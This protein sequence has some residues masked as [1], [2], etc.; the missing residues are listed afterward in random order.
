[1]AERELLRHR[2]IAAGIDVGIGIGLAV[3][4]SIVALVARV[5]PGVLGDIAGTLVYGGG[6]V[7][8]LA[9][10]LGRDV[11]AGG[12]S[13]GKKAQDLS[14]VTSSGKAIT[15][16]HS[17][18]R[19][20]IFA[21]GYSI[22]TLSFLASL[23]PFLQALQCLLTGAAGFVSVAALVA[24]VAWVLQDPE[25]LRLGDKFAGTRV[26]WTDEQ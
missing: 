6:V 2:M 16:E 7:V 22:A 5:L 1:M 19:N 18:K 12:R 15:L 10:V 21:A 17:V 23:I 14:V 20:A 3:A 11:L 24:E 13:F 9:Y 8:V 26:V 4:V 25:G